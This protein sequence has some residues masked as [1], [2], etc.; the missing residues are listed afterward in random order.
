MTGVRTYRCTRCVHTY[1]DAEIPSDPVKPPVE[2]ASFSLNAGEERI[3]ESI[4]VQE[5]SYVYNGSTLMQLVIQ[6]T[7]NDGTPV[8]ETLSFSYDAS[9]VP[10]AVDYNGTDY[11][12][13]AN[14]QGDV[15]A[16]LNTSGTAV[17]E[18]T[19]DA[20]GNIHSITGNHASSIGELN[21]LRYRGYV[22]DSDS[23]YYY[24]QSRYYNPEVGRFINADTLASTGQLGNNMFSYCINNPVCRIDISGTFSYRVEDTL[25]GYNLI[26]EESKSDL[27]GT[28]TVS[29]VF[30]LS[31]HDEYKIILE[32]F[33]LS[34]SF[35]GCEL[36]ISGTTLSLNY[37]SSGLSFDKYTIPFV[38]GD[39]FSHSFSYSENGWGIESAL[40]VDNF[41]FTLSVEYKPNFLNILVERISAKITSSIGG[42]AGGGGKWTHSQ[43]RANLSFS[44]RVGCDMFCT[45]ANMFR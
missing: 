24:L 43:Q 28:Y 32:W 4:V 5:Y 37:S 1:S 41:D 19:Y 13:V 35:T 6:T 36:L 11:Y 23:G 40:S 3:L 30:E 2:V 7:V 8:T 16:L 27:A 22:Y 25:E 45:T 38:K 39:N 10:L 14:L 12:Y 29:L 26:I 9:G 18:Y 15:V 17:V 31:Y 44:G 33:E 20:W 34:T 42:Y 21:P